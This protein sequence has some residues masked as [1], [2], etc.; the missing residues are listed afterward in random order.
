MKLVRSDS[1]EVAR[2][3]ASASVQAR[4]NWP[5]LGFGCA[6]N[7]LTLLIAFTASLCL[8][9][10]AAAWFSVPVFLALN[11]YVAW[12][13]L[14]SRKQWVIAGCDERFYVRLFAWRRSAPS[15]GNEPDI[16]VLE[17]SEIA[18]MSVR[19]LDVFLDG[20]KPKIVEWLVIEPSKAVAQDI[21]KHIRPL[22]TAHDPDKAVYVANEEGR[23][24]IGWNWWH[25][26]LRVFL[27]QV[28]KEC[29]SVFIA[30]EE[31]SELDLNGIWRR[32]SRNLRKDL[33]DLSA[34]ERQKLVQAMR[35][36]FG[37]ECAGLLARYKWISFRESSAFLSE[38]W[39]EEAGAGHSAIQG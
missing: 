10:R 31:L 25:P 23:F 1:S 27:H 14:S 17:A 15:D 28:V 38:V 20:L 5:A 39:R 33:K 30:D 21:F 6:A 18:S 4:W 32:I 35:L 2:S 13:A 37:C 11:G 3:I 24:S 16:L 8:S 12:R 9:A 36:G 29:P 26:A 22:L 34:L 7:L 19:T